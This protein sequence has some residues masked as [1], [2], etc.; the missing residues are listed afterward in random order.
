MVL[1][2]MISLLAP[3]GAADDEDYAYKVADDYI[4]LL[5]VSSGRVALRGTLYPGPDGACT[6][7]VKVRYGDGF[8]IS[9]V[10]GDVRAESAR[11]V[12]SKEPLYPEYE[13]YLLTVTPLPSEVTDVP[14]PFTIRVKSGDRIVSLTGETAPKQERVLFSDIR[15]NE[16]GG[17]FYRFLDE[18]IEEPA[19]VSYPGG[20]EVAFQGAYGAM[21]ADLSADTTPIAALGRSSLPCWRFIDE[22]SFPEEV[23][24][25]IQA[26]EDAEI[27]EILESGLYPVKSTY[28]NGV[29]RFYTKVLTGYAVLENP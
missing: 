11:L 12:P 25:S 6:V 9:S 16:N 2:L 10:D 26:Q 17:V 28:E 19:L 22:P 3:A 15:Y 24:V 27:Y 13:Y 4:S 29:H 7:R 20:L 8:F 5:N 1:M 14:E 18:T 21:T 23:M